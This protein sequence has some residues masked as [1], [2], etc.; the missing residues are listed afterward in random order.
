MENEFQFKGFMKLIGFFMPGAF[1]KQS[2]KYMK[3][4]K[5]FAEG[6]EKR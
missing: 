4:F 2:F 1:E 5:A 3:D 6:C